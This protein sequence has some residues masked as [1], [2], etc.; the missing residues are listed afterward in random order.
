MAKHAPGKLSAPFVR[1]VSSPG[2]YLDGGSLYFQVDAA[3]RKRWYVRVMVHGK[4]KE[5][6]VGPYPLVSLA[7]ARAKAILIRKK[8]RD[9]VDPIEERREERKRAQASTPQTCLSVL[10]PF[11]EMSAAV[12]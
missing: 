4:R 8:V 12:D 3:D 5:V 7:E 11:L 2:K 6:S 1:T 10:P 9:G